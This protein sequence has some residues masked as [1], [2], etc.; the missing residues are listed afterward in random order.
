MLERVKQVNVFLKLFKKGST[1][2]LYS[3]SLTDRTEFPQVL[4]VSRFSLR[5]TVCDQHET[6]LVESEQKLKNSIRTCLVL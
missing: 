3:V 6:L 4:K 1:G 2:V 5:S